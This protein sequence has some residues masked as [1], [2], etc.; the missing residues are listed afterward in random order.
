VGET[1]RHL[2]NAWRYQL[3]NLYDFDPA[4][5]L[6]ADAAL[7]GVDRWVLAQFS[8]L[9]SEVAAAYSRYEFHL[10]Y[11]QVSQFAAVEL[12]AI[13]H[14]VV[15]D[16][17]Y[18]DAADSPRRR[19]TQ[20]VLYR[21]ARGLCAALSPILAFTADEAWEFIPGNG[22]S[23][24]HLAVWEHVRVTLAEEELARWRK[25]FEVRDLALAA[26]E[27][28]RQ[29]KNIGKALDAQVV[30]R[31]P[32]KALEPLTEED[33][34]TMRE[35]L[36][37]SRLTLQKGEESAGLAVEVSKADGLKCE[38]C[39]HWET[40]VGTD[41]EHPTLCGRCAAVVRKSVRQG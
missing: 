13:Y 12:S 26:L 19:S 29:A 30:L 36:N 7:T 1:Y 28:E 22:G 34:E 35:L 39:W 18:T 14:D 3:S 32:A 40:D 4:R 31:G 16:R 23:S 15:K 8:K 5:D 27:R 24:V 38:R 2:R 6:V 37:V 9:E 10:V 17:L 11:Q 33:A 41:A 21:L 25:I 20:T